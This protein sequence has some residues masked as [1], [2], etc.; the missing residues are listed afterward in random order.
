VIR[1]AVVGAAVALALWAVPVQAGE[2]TV[3]ACDAAAGVNNSWAAITNSGNMAA[4]TACPSSGNVT[5]GLVS[6]NAVKPSQSSERVPYG[7]FAMQRFDAPGG[8]A[9]TGITASFRLARV[10]GEPWNVGLS[11]G[12]QFLRGCRG[13][14][15]GICFEYQDSPIYLPV[16]WSPVIYWEASC[17]N[18]SGCLINDTLFSGERAR[19]AARVYYAAVHIADFSQPSLQLTG[20]QLLAGG[21]QRSSQAISFDASDNVGIRETGVYIDGKP[22]TRNTKPCDYTQRAPCPQGGD[23]YTLDTASVASDGSH[24]LTAE[25]IDTAGNVSRVDAAIRIDNSPPAQPE[26]LTLEGGEG[27]RAANAF[28]L[29]WRNPPESGTAPIAGVRYELCPADGGECQTG[30]RDDRGIT[31]LTDVRVPKAG[32]Y[33]L[34]LWLRD[35]AGNADKRTAAAPIHLRL[36]DE[37]PDLTFDPQDPSDPARVSVNASDRTSGVSNGAIEL[38]RRGEDAWRPVATS[39]DGGK[40]VGRIDDEQLVDAT[41]DL[42]ARGIDQAGNERSTDRFAD[43]SPAAI[44]LPV[45]IKTLLRVGVRRVSIRGRGKRRTRHVRLL[46]QSR[47]AYGRRA[48]LSGRLTA[49]DGNPLADVELRVWQAPRQDGAGFAPVATLKTS[50]TG[51]FTYVAPPGTSRTLRFRYEGTPTIRARSTDVRLLVGART[52]LKVNRHSVLNGETVTFAGR[53]RGQPV[54]AGGKLI[55]LQAWVRGRFRTFATTTANGNGI[56]RYEYRFDGTRGRQVYRFRARVPREV[57]Y[58]YESGYSN[59]VRVTVRGL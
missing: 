22:I 27:W 47:L 16:P 10:T 54:P 44:T 51:R 18:W 52:T 37:A 6:I 32:D 57:A 21:W 48:R 59:R 56:W 20:G 7:T 40:L 5:A 9:I 4:Y 39:V 45:R 36:D 12:S 58:P 46:G 11:N 24:T 41:Y 43:G 8:A 2:Y 3:Y 26:E 38:R 50:A 49:G 17:W 13:D 14:T 34:R 35:A 55:E 30:G 23:E 28:R 31:T 19:A 1:R 33:V 29:R 25:A 53:L 42:R 15:G